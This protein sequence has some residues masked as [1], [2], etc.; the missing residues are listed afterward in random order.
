[1]VHNPTPQKPGIFN[2]RLKTCINTLLVYGNKIITENLKEG[3]S[4]IEIHK[5]K[6]KQAGGIT[7]YGTSP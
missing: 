5:V 3:I 6:H 7:M 1:M 2:K 4:E